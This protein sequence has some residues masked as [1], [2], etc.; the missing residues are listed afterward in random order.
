VLSASTPEHLGSI[1][2]QAPEVAFWGRS[3]VGK[4]SLINALTGRKKL[5][6][7]SNTPGRT[8][9]INFFNLNDALLLADLPGYG[10]AKASKTEIKAWNRF[11]RFYMKNRQEL[12][13]VVLLIDARRGIKDI[14][15]E[16]MLFLDEMGVPYHIVL[17]KADQVKKELEE[18]V[19][20]V[21]LA[22]KQHPAAWPSVMV[23]S[24]DKK[25]GILELQESLYGL[26]MS[27]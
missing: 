11:I 5:A 15:E 2:L 22:L 9:Q 13:R 17:T 24:A 26:A 4:S 23:T 7:A 14:D 12:Q 20:G 1:P 19:Q 8:R 25:T 27:N 18:T 10:H 16:I 6:R 21:E 3:N